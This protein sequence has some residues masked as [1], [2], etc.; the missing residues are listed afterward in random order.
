MDSQE[1]DIK[2]RY[3]IQYRALGRRFGHSTQSGRMNQIK[4]SVIKK[5]YTPRQT[6]SRNGIIKNRKEE[7]VVVRSP[8]MKCSAGRHEYLNALLQKEIKSEGLVVLGTMD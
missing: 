2:E 7:I 1:I 8:S 3:G 5:K 6:T 4:L